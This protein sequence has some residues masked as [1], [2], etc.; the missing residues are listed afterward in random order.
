QPMPPPLPED[1]RGK[2]EELLRLA[3]ASAPGLQADYRVEKGDAAPRIVSAAQETRCDLIVMG[4]HGRTGL[5]R[6]LMGS[7]AEHVVRTAPCPVVTV[8]APAKAE[9][10]WA[11]GQ[12]D[13]VARHNARTSP[14]TQEACRS[15]GG[16]LNCTRRCVIKIS[17]ESLGRARRVAGGGAGCRDIPRRGRCRRRD[18]PSR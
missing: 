12:S 16:L 7:V 9:V 11:G 17:R 18:R 5:G 1:P 6:A 13:D 8:K 10:P 3:Q 15:H 4:T 14:Q 2:L